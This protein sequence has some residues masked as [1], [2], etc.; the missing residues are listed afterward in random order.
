MP[1]ERYKRILK[2]NAE[3][4]REAPYN[5]C[6]RWCE[7]CPAETQGR[8][9]LYQDELE[10]KITSIA[11]GRE[12]DDPEV[13][14]EVLRWQY[15]SD[16]EA[17]EEALDD[18]EMEELAEIEAEAWEAADDAEIRKIKDHMRFVREHPMPKTT[19]AYSRKAEQF[20]DAVY[21]RDNSFS[22]DTRYDLE[23]VG[24]YHTLLPP[25]MQ[26]TLA[27]FHEPVT[28]GDIS[29]NDAV[30]QLLVCKKSVRLSLEALRRL[31]P[32]FPAQATLF[33]EMIALLNNLFS[34]LKALEES[35]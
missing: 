11:H 35:V 2:E 16:A 29:L 27:G 17:I 25:K 22:A 31:K 26:R 8:C 13:A 10:Q 15:E 19:E 34:R 4:E 28:E 32:K 24:W 14:R 1:S 12:E 33:I 18:E 21:R 6:D 30:A 7:R 20:L 9:R 3:F 23:T 5:F